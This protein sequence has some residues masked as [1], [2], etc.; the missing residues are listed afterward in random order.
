MVV[1]QM[2]KVGSTS[3]QRSL[4]AQGC[5][6]YH[7]H[8]LGYGGS[9][10]AALLKGSM[11]QARRRYMA[12]RLTRLLRDDVRYERVKLI[13]PVREPVARNVSAFFQTLPIRAVREQSV[14]GLQRRFIETYKHTLPLD[15]FGRKFR[16]AVGVDVMASGFDAEQGWVCLAGPRV[17]VL[18]LKCE[19]SDAVK[20]GCVG[21]FVGVEG[22]TL[23]RDNAAGDKAV[24]GVYRAFCD[25]LVLPGDLLERMMGAAYTRHFY[26]EAERAAMAARWG[27]G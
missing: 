27:G 9:V 24:A 17:S 22:F 12:Y 13:T 7:T 14:A 21:D 25:S 2:G 5:R 18:V 15:W 6:S 20:A 19:L 26:T 16:P 10:S 11:V 23:G 3:I 1:Y 8:D 4:L